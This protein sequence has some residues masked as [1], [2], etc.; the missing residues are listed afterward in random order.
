VRTAKLFLTC[1]LCLPGVAMAQSAARSVLV[2]PNVIDR[3]TAS[4][5]AR[6]EAARRAAV[7]DRVDAS[8]DAAVAPDKTGPIQQSTM[9]DS[10]DGFSTSQEI[11]APVTPAP[12]PPR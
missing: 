7:A 9:T 5:D 3:A 6:A 12:T 1:A 8:I 2:P 11:G 10:P 4:T